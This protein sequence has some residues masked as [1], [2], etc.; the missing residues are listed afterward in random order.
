MESTVIT[1]LRNIELAVT[2]LDRSVQF[3]SE[4]WGLQPVSSDGGIVHLRARA[5]EHHVVTLKA[6]K[7]P[8]LVGITL[9]TRDK[10]CVDSLYDK[11]KSAS[12]TI[13]NEPI[14]LPECA[15][16]GYGFTM[17]GPEGLRVSISSAVKEWQTSFGDVTTPY[18]LT[19][20]VLNSE[21]TASQ[22]GFFVD[23]LGFRLS[24]STQRM[25]FLRCGQ[26]HHTIAIAHGTNL[27]LNH[28]A[29][30]LP[31]IDALMYG[32]GRLAEHGYNVE[33]GLGR[34][35]P[36]NNVFS[37]FID[38]DGFAIEYTCDMQQVDEDV[39]QPQDANY[40]AAF[41]K[42]PCRWGMARKPSDRLIASMSGRVNG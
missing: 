31:D 3:Y 22:C 16:G 25:E 33:W 21:D 7:A 12:I 4:A 11:A 32:A 27:S 35:G 42:R 1:S 19:H 13:E 40:W 8:G 39:F 14:P 5:A 2:D 37:Y 6:A 18:K 20:V 9:A 23:V 10:D 34:H 15:G 36:G 29:F 26:D 28:A 38:P 17:I 30:E 41:P 24:D